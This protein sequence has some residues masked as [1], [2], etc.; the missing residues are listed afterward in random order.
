M[1]HRSCQVRV[2]QAAHIRVITGS[3]P[4]VGRAARGRTFDDVPHSL[5]VPVSVFFVCLIDRFENGSS[6]ITNVNVPLTSLRF[7][8]TAEAIQT[9]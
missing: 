6:A 7:M 2:E 3:G 1:S 9:G 5:I 4:D 8:S